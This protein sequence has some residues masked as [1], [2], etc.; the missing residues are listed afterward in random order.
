[1]VSIGAP[2]G[3]DGSVASRRPCEATR[4]PGRDHLRHRQF[5]QVRQYDD[6]GAPTGCDQAKVAPAK[7]H[8]RVQRGATQRLH[9]RQTSPYQTT[10]HVDHPTRLH[11]VIWEHIVGADGQCLWNL[12]QR[13]ER[14]D[15]ARQHIVVRTT[16]LH[17]ETSAQLGEQIFAAGDLVI[18]FDAGGGKSL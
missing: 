14:I 3:N 4:G 12:R 10:Q 7:P 5:G 9:R 11:Q 17:G 16:E 1:M 15:R 13:V 6:I 8:G 18:T 2:G